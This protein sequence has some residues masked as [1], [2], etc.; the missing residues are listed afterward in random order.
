MGV[1]RGPFHI[2][3]IHGRYQSP[4]AESEPA[5]GGGVHAQRLL[6]DRAAGVP[7]D[8]VRRPAF[9]AHCAGKFKLYDRIECRAQDNRWVAD[10]MVN[11]VGKLEAGVW[12][13]WYVDLE[14]QAIDRQAEATPVAS[15]DYTISFAPK[16][17]W[18]VIRNSDKAVIHKDE[19]N[20]AA[21]K[22]WLEAH[23]EA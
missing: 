21:A 5:Q 16:H 2:G 8:S 20:E 1:R 11:S 22:A 15:G 7:L 9:W 13:L 17:A 10:L 23:L 14:A 18:R 19:P 4:A 6:R 3:T 12:V